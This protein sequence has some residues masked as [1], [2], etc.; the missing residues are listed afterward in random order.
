MMRHWVART[1]GFAMLC[2]AAPVR[3]ADF[4]VDPV[5]GDEFAQRRAL[6]AVA[7]FVDATIIRSIVLP[8][9]M[10]LLGDWN[11]YLPSWLG[12]LPHVT[13]EAEPEVEI[14]EADPMPRPRTGWAPTPPFVP[15]PVRVDG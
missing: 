7:V 4:Y 9:V 8:A 14:P 13:I 10:T 3:A 15:E 6:V 1:V 12:W 11:W 5:N 2:I